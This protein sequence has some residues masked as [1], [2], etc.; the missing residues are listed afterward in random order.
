MLRDIAEIVESKP[1][2]GKPRGG[3]GWTPLGVEHP[4]V[5]I[6]EE[7][8]AAVGRGLGDRAPVFLHPD[9]RGGPQGGCLRFGEDPRGFAPDG[10]HFVGHVVRAYRNGMAA[11]R[12]G[13]GSE[14][15]AGDGARRARKGF[16]DAPDFAIVGFKGYIGAV[17][18]AG[19]DGA[20]R[21]A[22]VIIQVFCAWIPGAGGRL[23]SYTSTERGNRLF[24]DRRRRVGNRFV[25]IAAENVGR[26]G[27]GEAVGGGVL[28]IWVTVH[29]VLSPKFS[30]V[31]QAQM[32][33][34]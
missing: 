7:V 3:H 1:G 4:P 12:V 23:Q 10:R 28:I 15:F 17:G 29:Y 27:E 32:E 21:V 33:M 22:K 8:A 11:E 20:N 26:D 31:R 24:V 5:G 9:R 30:S 14:P 16:R 18:D 2:L 13:K 6:A 25:R 19:N 34:K